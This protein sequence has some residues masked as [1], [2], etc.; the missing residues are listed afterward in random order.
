MMR[1]MPK[2]ERPPTFNPR[3]IWVALG[4]MVIFS[5]LRR[6]WLGEADRSLGALALG[7]ILIVILVTMRWNREA[8]AALRRRG[9]KYDPRKQL[10]MERERMLRQARDGEPPQEHK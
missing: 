2:E 4:V 3:M 10:Q 7:G 1:R 9:R 6:V 8:L 5:L